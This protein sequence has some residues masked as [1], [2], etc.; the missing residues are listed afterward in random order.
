MS[1]APLPVSIRQV[2]RETHDTLSLRLEARPGFR[3]LPGQFNMLYA[4]GAG[5]AAI[6]I[7]GDPARPESISHT[8]RAVGGVTKA[9]SALR[10]GGWL[11]LRGPFGSA[12][13]LEEA[14]G[15][16]VLLVAGGLG[17]A[18]LRPLLYH[19]LRHRG[20]F[21][22]VTLLYGAR[23]PEE[24]IYQRELSR[25]KARADLALEVTVDHA[26]AGWS[27]QVGVVPALLSGLAL[28]AGE[29]VAMLCGPEVMMRFSV[30]ELEHRGLPRERIYVSMERN[31]K[32]AIGLC[33]HCQ[34]GPFFVCK[35]GPVF[36]FDRVA[37]LF[38]TR[39]I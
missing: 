1:T 39:E 17:L 19:L 9:L 10:R 15:R 24:L 31:M 7:S 38:H 33:G 25:W 20:D 30:R 6:S 12:W 13:P 26:G 8:I 28:D 18:P 5:E 11:G 29:T 32:C 37:W 14:K 3:F 36:R 4:F 34:Y 21:G 2:R 27:G 22:R 16:D 23:A 35:E